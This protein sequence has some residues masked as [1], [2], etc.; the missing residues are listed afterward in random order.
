MFWLF[1]A[2]SAAILGEALWTLKSVAGFRRFFFRELTAAQNFHFEKW[3]KVALLAP[4][5]GVEPGLREN[6]ESW[7]RLDYPDFQIFF[8]VESENDP[9]MS[10][11]QC[12]EK[13]VLLVAGISENCGQK[14]HNLKFAVE[15]L[16]SEYA[17]IAFIDSDCFVRPDWLRNLVRSC[18]LDPQ[19]AAS[20]YRWFTEDQNF[21]SLLRSAWNSTVLT[22]FKEKGRDNFA[23]G[24]ST[25]ISRDLFYESRVFDFWSGS[26]SDDYSLTRA[27]KTSGRRVN[28]VPG[29]LAL[30]RDSIAVVDFFSWAFRQL[31]ITRIYHPGLWRAALAYHAGWFLWIATGLMFPVPFW[32]LFLTVQMIQ[33]VK[34]DWRWRCVH[35]AIGSST[36]LRICLWTF[37]PVIGFCNL[38]LLVSTIFTRTI[39]WR[40]VTYTLRGPGSVAI[41]R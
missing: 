19:N 34:A 8:I 24:G 20:G 9:A 33:S 32:I 2:L 15:R 26:I 16:P 27:L 5:K 1:L 39:H 29:A 35:A 11:I 13:G 18:L 31:L 21:G 12:F 38:L 22:L 14:V 6:I 37:G 25:A 40:G 36:K 23:W 41:R 3:P 10:V 28:F 7:F 30:T 17:V 4:C